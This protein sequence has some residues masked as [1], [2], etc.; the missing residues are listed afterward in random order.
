[1]MQ[2][3]VPALLNEC[4]DGLNIQPDGIYVDVT[5]GG[6]G[7]SSEILKR[8]DRG[9]L[10][11]F[12]QDADAEM[13]KPVDD[14]F[15]FINQ[16][17]RFLRNN[18]LYHGVEAING[19][20][21]DLGVSSRQFD[22]PARGFSYRF[23]S[24]LDMRMSQSAGKT[25]ADIVNGY[26]QEQLRKILKEYGEFRNAGAIAS[27]IVE[28]RKSKSLRTTLDLVE[29]VSD[30]LPVR[31]ENKYLSR[32]FQ[33]LRMEVNREMEFLG[34]MLLQAQEMLVRGGRIAVV[35]YHS[36]EDRLVKNFF[37]TGNFEG[38]EKKDFYGNP[39]SP[40]V[41]VNRKVIS[42]SEDEILRNRRARSARLRIAEKK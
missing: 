6:G 37:R 31:S 40:F 29:S 38:L 7:H 8:L 4:I 20:V 21:A 16:N 41:L 19:L 11:A 3:H 32:L 2:Y 15:L 12:D 13:N 35:A 5:F 42:P 24:E 26:T 36:I 22:D 30:Y 25:A 33:A 34:E 9:K 27:A 14:R 39:E 28:Q 10:I 18:L 1:M 17:F 23:D